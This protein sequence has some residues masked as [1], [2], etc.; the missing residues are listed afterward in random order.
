MKSLWY[1]LPNQNS[2]HDYGRLYYQHHVVRIRY[3][4]RQSNCSALA[5]TGG[6]LKGGIFPVFIDLLYP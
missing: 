2:Y 1:L 3:A 6:L 4:A 5:T